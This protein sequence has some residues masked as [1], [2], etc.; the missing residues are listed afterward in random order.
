ML[1][2]GSV[3]DD[4]GRLVSRSTYMLHFLCSVFEC[5]ICLAN[6]LKGGLSLFFLCPQL[7]KV[8]CFIGIIGNFLLP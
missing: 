1:T 2:S 8:R 3:V 7:F 4:S 5:V 6:V